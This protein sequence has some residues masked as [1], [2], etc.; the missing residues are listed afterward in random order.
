MRDSCDPS[1]AVHP[2]ANELCV[3]PDVEEEAAEVALTYTKLNELSQ[4]KPGEDAAEVA[5]H[6]QNFEN[7]KSLTRRQLM[8]NSNISNS[9]LLRD[10]R[11]SE[12]RVRWQRR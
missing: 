2:D 11:R 9:K 6:I 4:L 5:L 1:E 10:R 12:R 7:V 3:E 8:L